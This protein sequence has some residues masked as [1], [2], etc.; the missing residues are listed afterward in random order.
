MANTGV[1][2]ADATTPGEFPAV[3][4]TVYINGKSRNDYKVISIEHSAGVVP[5]KA[6]L[7]WIPS[8]ILTPAQDV[9][10]T[11]LD[12]WIDDAGESVR[13]LHGS[14]VVIR[15]G[16]E[17]IFCG[18]LLLR[19]DSG[20]ADT[21]LWTASDDR[22]IMSKIPIR[23]A[24]VRDDFSLTAR[25]LPRYE[26]HTNPNGVWNCIGWTCDIP[27]HPLNGEVV[28]VFASRGHI[29][30]SYESPDET[31]TDLLT[32]SKVTAW[33]PRRLLTYLYM[34]AHMPKGS[35]PGVDAESK[36]WREIISGELFDWDYTSIS[37]AVGKDAAE[38]GLDPLDRKIAD[39]KFQGM[40]MLQAISDT[41]TTAGTHD[42]SF[43]AQG[44]TEAVVDEEGTTQNVFNGKAKTKIDLFPIGKTA[45]MADNTTYSNIP[46]L[47]SGR[48]SNLPNVNTAYDF[49]LSEDSSNTRMSCLV[50]GD[51]IRSETRVTINSGLRIGWSIAS[52]ITPEDRAKG[53]I[54]EQEAFLAIVW[55]G[56]KS[57]TSGVKYAIYPEGLNLDNTDIP[58][59][60]DWVTAD[61]GTGRELAYAYT[62]EALQIARR[63]FP[64]VF[65]AFYINS[66]DSEIVTALKGFDSVYSDINEFPQ[67]NIVRPVLP[68]QL[69][70][71][72]ADTSAGGGI[73]NAL[74][75]RFPI[76]VSVED[77]QLGWIDS[78]WTNA[79]MIGEGLFLIDMA[80]QYDGTPYCI[81]SGH[82]YA[83]GDLQ[84]VNTL[85]CALKNMRINLAIPMDHR[86]Y[87]Y[88]STEEDF[89][90]GGLSD[91]LYVNANYAQSTGGEFMQYIDSGSTYKE[92]HQV[93][94]YPSDDNS[95]KNRLLPPGSE[96]G[97]AEYAAQRRLFQTQKINRLSSWK[98]VGIRP[99]WKV[100]QWINQIDQITALDD[101]SIGGFG[102]PYR[103]NAPIRS[104][105]FDYENQDTTIGG[106]I[107]ESF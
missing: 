26:A 23:G 82:L 98:M 38:S 92:E 90:N 32:V 58:K 33:T 101:G 94:S 9:S 37:G 81:Y 35:M 83:T 54:S 51:V 48:P 41:L 39:M 15:S 8:A 71:Q 67:A 106:L 28:P 60:S 56:A 93:N 73:E 10:P 59:V 1:I 74:A 86:V 96:A 30:V 25:F 53:K 102:A 4:P 12:A 3:L 97:N 27:D 65:R 5:G 43:A 76:R 72:L 107:G 14:R 21:V 29:K 68:N 95:V 69:Q 44:Q 91:W 61:G 24:V 63:L 7:E 22:E 66:S 80:E 99:E 84:T 52:D 2:T 17:T 18:H 77:D 40:A 11:T 55:G 57:T 6:I 19:Q 46:L 13:E 45:Q 89:G 75:A 70:Y 103:I 20:A 88:K 31:F 105:V 42:I 87:G 34:I 64:R 50:E 85:D 47:R 49:Q 79:S 36:V 16:L 100:G 104:I 62:P 78:G